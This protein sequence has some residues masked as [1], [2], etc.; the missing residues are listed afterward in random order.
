MMKMIFQSSNLLMKAI[1]GGRSA[2]SLMVEDIE[3]ENLE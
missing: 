3:I 2:A 1:F